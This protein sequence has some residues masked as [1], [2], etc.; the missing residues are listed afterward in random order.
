MHKIVLDTNVLISAII[1]SGYPY[2]ILHNLVATERIKICLSE[3]VLTE[4]TEVATRAKFA[5]Y[6][7]FKQN[8]LFIITN[9]KRVGKLYTP[10]IQLDIISDK[11]DNRFLELAVFSKADFLITGNTN[12]FTFSEYESVKIISPKDYIENY[13]KV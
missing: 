5:Q 6:K 12:H 3:Q 1:S 7:D 2:R 11:A 4:Y 10:N 13:W 9:I 8:S